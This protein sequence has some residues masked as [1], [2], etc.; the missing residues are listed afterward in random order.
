MRPVLTSLRFGDAA[1]GQMQALT[2]SPIRR[3]ADDES[4]MGATHDLYAPQREDD[5]VGAARGVPAVRARGGDLPCHLTRPDDWADPAQ[6]TTRSP[7]TDDARRRLMGADVSRVRHDP[8]RNYSG[9]LQQQGRVV[10]DADGNEQLAITDRR[11]RAAAA[12]LGSPGPAPGVR[13]TAVVPRTTPDAFRLTVTGGVMTIGRGRMY[14]DGLLAENHGTGAIVFDP[15]LAGPAGSRGHAVP[16][17]AVAARA[18]PG[19]AADHRHPTC[20]TS[21]S[22]S[23]S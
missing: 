6:R 1:Y 3:G 15:L 11:H 20:S 17:P 7:P 18:A 12:D 14:V 2:P 10:L 22:G 9:V 23:A 4:E 13:G 5:L 16:R 8:R 21:T 19:G